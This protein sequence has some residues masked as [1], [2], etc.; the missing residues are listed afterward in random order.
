M[1]NRILGELSSDRLMLDVR[2]LAEQAPGRLSGTPA[3]RRAAGYIK[4]Q[5]DAM[6]VPMVLHEIDA[7]VSFPVRARIEVEGP[8]SRRI[9]ARACAHSASTTAAGV[10]AD[11]VYVGGGGADDYAGA[12]AEGTITM[13]ELAKPPARPQKARFAA[14][15]GALAHIVSNWGP[16]GCNAVPMGTCKAIWGNP[17]ASNIAS[18]P[19]IPVVGISRADAEWLQKQMKSGPVRLRI[20]CE[21]ESRWEKVILP[22]ARIEGTEDPESFVLIAGHYDAWGPGATDNA[23]GNAIITEIARVLSAHSD[24]LRRS[25]VL[26]FWP[27][28]ENGIMSG[29]SWFVDEH[30]DDFSRNCVFTI[31]VDQAGLV[32]ATEPRAYCTREV[33]VFHTSVASKVFGREDLTS[34]PLQRAGDQSFFGL[35]IPSIYAT[36]E[37]S[38][39]L[40][41]E[42]GGAVFGWWYHSD[43]DTVDKVDPEVLLADARMNAALAWEIAT[44]LMLPF[45]YSSS[46]DRLLARARELAAVDARLKIST[47]VEQL[48]KLRA[49]LAELLRIRDG[50]SAEAGAASVAGYNRLIREVGARLSAAAATISGRWMQDDYGLASLSRPFPGLDILPRLAAEGPDA[51]FFKLNWTDAA[52]Q[53]NR[54][55]DLLAEASSAVEAFLAARRSQALP[56]RSRATK[57]ASAR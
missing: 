13:S 47:L 53:R 24:R 36:H 54:I 7:Y 33:A 27:G 57:S 25:V 16:A 15:N 9:E 56:H 45:D 32:Q 42:W 14:Q 38:R 37:P 30:W 22:V 50:L 28:H 31:T 10:A 41:D 34:E 6:G 49:L 46:V 12:T 1:L 3:E 51:E 35:G 20:F 21:V 11:L 8:V 52:R 5:F 40:K 2:Y 19:K 43:Q 44:T 55:H 17:S 23:T 29:S 39:A 48:E 26:A 4:S 18:L